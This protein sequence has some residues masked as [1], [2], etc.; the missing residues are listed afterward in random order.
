[1]NEQIFDRI[2]K[3]AS[4]DKANNDGILSYIVEE[5]GE[6]ATCLAVE[7]GLKNR[8]LKETTQQECV[9][10]LISTIGLMT[11]YNIDYE[12]LQKYMEL[13]LKKWEKR[14][15]STKE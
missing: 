15:G 11:R 7:N 9:D 12:F 2:K 5:V 13:K 1:M 14:V 6:V 3:C 4:L 10:V 8:T